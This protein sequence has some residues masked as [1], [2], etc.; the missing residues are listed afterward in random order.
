[1]SVYETG[2]SI[3]MPE[4]GKDDDAQRADAVRQRGKKAAERANRKANK[5]ER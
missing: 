5:I 2:V 1:M 4:K 3:S